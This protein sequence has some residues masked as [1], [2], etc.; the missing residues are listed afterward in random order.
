MCNKK[1]VDLHRHNFFVHFHK[2]KNGKL[3]KKI[4]KQNNYKNLYNQSFLIKD[5][6]Q[7]LDN[8]D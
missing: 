4:F 3:R 1:S 7:K 5:K 6:T 2:K 8:N